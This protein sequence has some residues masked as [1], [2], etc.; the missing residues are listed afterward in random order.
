MALSDI[1]SYMTGTTILADGGA[2]RSG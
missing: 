2:V 1:A